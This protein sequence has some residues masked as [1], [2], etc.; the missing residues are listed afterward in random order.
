M[1]SH[2]NAMAFAAWA[3]DEFALAGT[4]GWRSSPR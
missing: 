2:R 3:A 1:V 4:T